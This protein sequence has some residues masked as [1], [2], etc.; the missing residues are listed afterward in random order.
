VE[1]LSPLKDAYPKEI[2]G[3]ISSWQRAVAVKTD[4]NGNKFAVPTLWEV[5]VRD[6]KKNG[7]ACIQFKYS[8]NS[9]PVVFDA[10]YIPVTTTTLNSQDY[11]PS[12]NCIQLPDLDSDG[13][14]T[15]EMCLMITP[16]LRGSTF[17]LRGNPGRPPAVC[18]MTLGSAH[19]NNDDFSQ[20]LDN[21]AVNVEPYYIKAQVWSR[22]KEQKAT[23]TLVSERL[24]LSNQI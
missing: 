17:Y 15:K 10:V 13:T 16:V 21:H 19:T 2:I 6:S 1:N 24:L 4:N 3:N 12:K 14:F 22:Q 8:P 5:G 23:I 11:E 18:Q 9:E 7:S 20:A